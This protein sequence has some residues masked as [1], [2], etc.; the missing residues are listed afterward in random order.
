LSRLEPQ[1]QTAAWELIRH[2]QARPS[3]TTVQQVVSTIR[4]AISTG[5]QEREK[6]VASERAPS[7]SKNATTQ[8][9]QSDQLGTLCR[10][11]NRITSWDPIAV[12]LADDELRLKRHLKAA[13]EL[14]T[15]CEAFICA[16]AVSGL[17]ISKIRNA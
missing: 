1:L 14:K 8:Y 6:Q 11:V 12:A 10:W 9:R 4:E 3:G 7:G 2:I 15:F 13:R 16:I 17:C 5:W